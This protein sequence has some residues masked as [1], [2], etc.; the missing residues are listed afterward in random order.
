[1]QA[2]RIAV[3]TL[4]MSPRDFWEATPR[5]FE[6]MCDGFR[7]AEDRDMTKLAWLTANVINIHLK[8]KDRVTVSQLLGKVI[9]SSKQH[10][11]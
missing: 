11:E 9:Q 8:R 7:A 3:G 6:H 2:E 4:Q 1:M 10:R 5:E